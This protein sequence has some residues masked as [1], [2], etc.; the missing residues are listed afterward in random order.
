MTL[1]CYFFAGTQDYI[2][3]I[4]PCG[5]KISLSMPD[6][7]IPSI[8]PSEFETAAVHILSNMGITR[9]SITQQNAFVCTFDFSH[10]ASF[11]SNVIFSTLYI[12]L[13]F[14]LYKS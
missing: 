9:S 13:N 4:Y 10:K 6:S 2:L 11:L 14:I 3:S 8:Y 7:L 12:V 1:Y 5:K